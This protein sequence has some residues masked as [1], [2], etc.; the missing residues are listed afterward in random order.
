MQELRAINTEI[1]KKVI[2]FNLIFI[3]FIFKIS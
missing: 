3:H 2:K 1:D